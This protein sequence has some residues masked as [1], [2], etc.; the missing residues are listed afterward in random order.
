[1]V[2]SS[3]EARNAITSGGVKVEEK[4]ITDVKQ[5]IT[6]GTLPLFIQVGKKKFGNVGAHDIKIV[7]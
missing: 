7:K 2:S 3:T 5:M 4:V 1:M 6:I